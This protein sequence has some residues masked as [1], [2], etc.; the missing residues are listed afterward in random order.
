MGKQVRCIG[1]C[2]LVILLFA[3]ALGAQET[4]ASLRGAILDPS[5]SRV[6]S[7]KVTA[8]QAETGYTRSSVSDAGGDYLLVLLPIGHYRLEV[9]AAGFRKYVQEGISLSVD[10]VA[11][12]AVHLQ[13]GL[14][15]ADRAGQSG[16][17]ASR[18]HQRPG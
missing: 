9:T 14:P 5:G 3:A 2:A 13:V 17:G 8:I 16:R 1:V 11:S 10:Q 7:A 15:H 12:L 4:T 6:P 18:D